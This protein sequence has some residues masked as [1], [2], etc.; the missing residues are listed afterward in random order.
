MMKQANKHEQVFLEVRR[1][2]PNA[3]S[4]SSGNK[5]RYAAWCQR[6]GAKVNLAPQNEIPFRNA[7]GALHVRLVFSGE[8]LVCSNS[9]TDKAKLDQ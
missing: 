7:T 9:L 6:C 5:L 1:M 2:R 4:I 8:L 3:G